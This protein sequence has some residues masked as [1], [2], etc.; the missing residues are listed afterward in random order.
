MFCPVLFYILNK[1]GKNKNKFLPFY[2]VFSSAGSSEVSSLGA[3][4]VVSAGF[5]VCS[6]SAIINYHDHDLD[7]DPD[8]DPDPDHDP[9]LDPDL[10]PDPDHDPDHDPD[11]DL[12]PDLDPDR[13]R[14]F[15]SIGISIWPDPTIRY[16][17][18]SHAMG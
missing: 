15:L 8:P 1:G 10:D 5:S 2:S 13:Y 3:S 16:P 4:S 7:H 14:D 11:L 17:P 9:D 12:D 6:C 18:A